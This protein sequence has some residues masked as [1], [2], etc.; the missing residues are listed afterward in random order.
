MLVFFAIGYYF[1]QKERITVGYTA[2]V[3]S[4]SI[5]YTTGLH[6]IIHLIDDIQKSIIDRKFSRFI[7]YLIASF[8]LLL[9]MLPFGV[10]NVL[11]STLLF[12]G[13]ISRRTTLARIQGPLL[14]ELLQHLDLLQYYNC[15]F[16]LTSM[17]ALL[18]ALKIG[19]NL[20]EKQLHLSFYMLF[21]LPFMA[22]E[23]FIIHI[24]HW[25]FT[26]MNDNEDHEFINMNPNINQI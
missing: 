20:Y 23:L 6:L 15:L 3:L 1:L 24:F 17:I 22:T 2:Y 8:I 12:Q 9:T 4:A 14:V 16:L 10:F 25:F 21:L 7:P 18:L 13:E 19:K 11:E 5:K 26:M